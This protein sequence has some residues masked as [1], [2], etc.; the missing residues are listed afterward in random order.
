VE[1]QTR[2]WQASMGTPWEVPVPRKV[3]CIEKSG[4]EAIFGRVGYTSCG[5]G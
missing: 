1:E 2:Q 5:I 4:G 3:R